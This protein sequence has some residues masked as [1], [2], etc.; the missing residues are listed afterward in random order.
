VMHSDGSAR[1][2]F[3]YASDAVAGFF[4]VLLKGRPGQAYNVANPA[5]ELSVLELAEMLVDLYPEKKLKVDRRYTPDSPGYIPSA[6][7][8]LIP[9]VTRL[10][11]LN[12]HAQ[13]APPAGFRRMIEAC[14]T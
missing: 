1:R 9:D 12:W 3:C 14:Q 4:T 8:R 11:A 10:S 7:S 2:A 5:G 13:I 6:Y